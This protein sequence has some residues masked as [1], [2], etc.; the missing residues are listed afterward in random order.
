VSKVRTPSFLPFRSVKRIVSLRSPPIPQLPLQESGKE[1]CRR[2]PSLSFVVGRNPFL[3]SFPLEGS[4]G[5]YLPPSF[6]VGGDESRLPFWNFSS[7]LAPPPTRIF[8][9]KKME[10]SGKAVFCFSPPV[11][12]A[13]GPFRSRFLAILMFLRP[14]FFVVRVGQSSLRSLLDSRDHWLRSGFFPLRTF[15]FHVFTP[16]HKPNTPHGPRCHSSASSSHSDFFSLGNSSRVLSSNV[17]FFP[18]SGHLTR[19]FPFPLRLSELSSS[20]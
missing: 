6:L 17:F 9:P 10:V 11:N 14:P 13:P 1:F 18:I 16:F 12:T 4:P 3:P 2:V 19:V 5:Q 20:H 7:P 15:P 8:T